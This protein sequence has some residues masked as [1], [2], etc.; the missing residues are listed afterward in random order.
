MADLFI[1]SN[2]SPIFIVRLEK[3]LADRQRLPLQHVI[4]VLEEVR[5][6]IC[7]AGRE[8]QR[9]KGF[10]RPSGD[11]GLELVAGSRGVLFQPG[12]VQAHIAI[13][14]DVQ[15][16]VLAAE[17]VISLVTRLGERDLHE[18]DDPTERQIVRRLNRIAKFQRTDKTELRM[19]V[20]KPSSQ[21]VEQAIFGDAAIETIR[22]LQ[23][24]VFEMEGLTVFGKLY[25]LRD[26][27]EEDEENDRG[28]WGE[29]RRENGETWRIQFAS[30]DTE[31][32]VSLFRKQVAVTGH[33][34]YYRIANPKLIVR[35]IVPDIDRDYETAFEELFGSDRESLGTDARALLREMRGDN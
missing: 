19:V 5:Q 6:M 9:D 8:V 21:A 33:A 25:E 2:E 20:Q 15:S 4:A 14:Q 7:E 12:S 22:S 26:R 29:L 31:R 3:G 34:K 35:E 30:S 11:F 23:A 1:D 27:D 10:E 32:A 17:R 24:P 18:L 28:F 16:G 13:T